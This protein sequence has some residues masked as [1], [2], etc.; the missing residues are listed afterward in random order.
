MALPIIPAAI[1]IRV[2]IAAAVLVLA[3]QRPSTLVRLA[4]DGVAGTGKLIAAA[5]KAVVR[6]AKRVARSTK[7]EYQARLIARAQE[8]VAVEAATLRNMTPDVRAKF[9]ADQAAIFARAE[10][11][12]LERVNGTYYARREKAAAKVAR[13]AKR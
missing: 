3:R 12:R 4:E 7:V 6:S 5:P 10:E 11:L 2:G 8:A 9:A 13:R 1:A